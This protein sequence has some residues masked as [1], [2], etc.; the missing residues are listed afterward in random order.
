VGGCFLQRGPSDETAR[1]RGYYTATSGAELGR[2]GFETYQ[3]IAPALVLPV[4]GVTGE[5]VDYQIRPDRPRIDAKS[6][7][8]VKYENVAGSHVRLDVNP[9]VRKYLGRTTSPLWIVEGVRK[10]D[11]LASRDLCAIALL[12]VDCFDVPEDWEHVALDGRHVY[13]AFDNDVMRKP[14]VHGALVRLTAYL[15]AKG[16]S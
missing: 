10:G 14:S 8:E 2:L 13:I 16:A 12:G 11:A 6:G 15:R 5:I 3:R 4:W 7:R 1:A 9:V